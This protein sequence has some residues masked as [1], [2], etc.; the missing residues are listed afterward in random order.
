L[1]VL[2]TAGS[3]K[4]QLAWHEVQAN[5]ANKFRSLYVCYNRPL[6]SH[7]ARRVRAEGLHGAFIFNFHALCDRVLK[8]AGV[9]VD[10]SVVGVF[11]TLAEQVLNL[12]Q[13]K[14][15]Q[16]D[17]IVVDEGQDFDKSW[18]DVLQKFAHPATRWIWL[19][20]PSQNLYNK[21]QLD[22]PDWVQ[23]TVNVNYRNPVHI[24][25]ALM[26]YRHLFALNNA[27]D[28]EVKAAC[29]LEGF[30]IEYLAYENDE[31]LFTQTSKAIT[32]CLKH[33]FTRDHIVVLSMRGHEKSKIL[34]QISLGPHTLRHFTGRYDEQ[35]NQLFTDGAVLAESVYRFKGQSAQAVVITEL[36][37]ENWSEKEFK[38]LFVAMTRSKMF[39]VFVGLNDSVGRLVDSCDF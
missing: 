22:F 17:S 33:G 19:E 26:R 37:F 10:Y 23:L 32:L 7:F 27:A 12:P 4:S 34:K 3:G 13:D 24:V 21:A 30:P 15:W 16:F 18:L 5:H 1:R 8:E 9:H 38:K 11:D 35:G 14:R 2:G 28:F 6:A 20:D 25:D 39:L 36:E 29:P 31:G